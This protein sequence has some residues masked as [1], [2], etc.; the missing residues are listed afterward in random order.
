MSRFAW[1]VLLLSSLAVA[2]EAASGAD[3]QSPPL[4]SGPTYS[5]MYCAGFVT[6]QAVSNKNMV[7]GG[8]YT[9]EQVLHA[10]HETVFIEGGGLQQGAQYSVVRELR[11]PNQYAPFAGQRALL[12]NTGKPYA[13]LGRVR[14][15]DL[16]GDV[17]VAKVEFSCEPIAPGD[18]VVPFQ[19]R[20]TLR[21]K[22][23]APMAE[24]SHSPKVDGQVVMARDFTTM[25]GFGE[26]VYLNLGSEQ[27]LKPGDY[28]LAVRDYAA[29]RIGEDEAL[30]YKVPQGDD[31]Q[32]KQRVLKVSDLEKLPRRVVGEMIV[33]NV[34]PGSATAMVTFARESVK[35]GDGV[36]IQ[37]GQ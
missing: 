8:R 6:R 14:V 25:V 33:L 18:L 16:H 26:K 9:P 30:S 20:M 5:D 29:N 7:M 1:V 19:E 22:T 23:A 17:A 21:F 10:T 34:M 32:A 27:G 4:G 11:D 2:Q 13:D 28:L 3:M 37:R 35:V 15:V 31:T 24:F 12:K 36:E